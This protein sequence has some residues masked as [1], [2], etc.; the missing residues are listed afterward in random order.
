M[1]KKIKCYKIR[2]VTGTT[3]ELKNVHSANE[4][5]PIIKKREAIQVN[6]YGVNYMLD[7]EKPPIHGEKFTPVWGIPGIVRGVFWIECYVTK[8][9]EKER[10]VKIPLAF[11]EL[12]ENQIKKI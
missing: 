12:L 2:V 1:I 4:K 8:L 3:T 7:C 11:S 5:K 10:W 9:R 6:T